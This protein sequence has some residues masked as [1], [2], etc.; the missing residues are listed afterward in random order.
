M[1][2]P[3]RLGVDPAHE[4][5]SADEGMTR[6]GFPAPPVELRSERAVSGRLHVG[7]GKA[8]LDVAVV[9]ED[10]AI[11]HLDADD[12]GRRRAVAEQALLEEEVAHQIHRLRKARRRGEGNR[13]GR[14]VEK[15]GRG[16]LR[17]EAL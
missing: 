13:I 8:Q 16:D 15:L 3:A 17:F 7:L 11:R 12:I 10:L 9:A 6:R 14:L 2:A 5:S 4:E 1:R